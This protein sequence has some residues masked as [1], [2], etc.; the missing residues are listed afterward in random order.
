MVELRPYQTNI[1]AKFQAAV[2]RGHHRII[3]VV[4][5]AGGKT[6]VASEIIKRAT[7]AY[8]R[9]VFIAHRNELLTQAHDKL[10]AFGVTAGIVK[11]GRDKDARPQAMVQICGVQTL[12]ARAVRAKTM[13]LPPA[14]I[15]FVDEAHHVRA[16]TYM[17]IIEQYPDAIIVGLTATPARGDGRGLGNVFELMI[18][19]P[20]V[21]ELI[22]QKYLVPAKI[23]APPPPDLR[24]VRVMSTG[25]YNTDDLSATMDPLVGDVIEHWL[26]HAQ[27]RRS[28]AFAVD[29]RHSVHLTDEFLKSDVRAEHLDGETDAKSRDAI[30]ARL[31]SGETEI[32]CNVGVLCEGYDLPDLGCITL[33]RPT[34][35]LVLYRQMIGRGL[36]PAPDKEHVV[37]LDHSGGVYRFGRPDDVIEWSLETD[38]RATNKTHEARIA[39]AGGSDP[40]VECKGC[41]HI[42][43]RGMACEACGYQP[44]PPARPVEYVDGELVELGKT[45]AAAAASET[46]RK[47][48]YA[49]L[50]G[51]Q[52]NARKRNGSPYANG[53]AANQYRTKHG[54]FPPWSWNNHPLATPSPATLRWIKSRQIAWAKRRAA[55]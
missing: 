2:E 38:E 10:A 26:K 40:F 36:R 21:L 48:F 12:H 7:A 44:K 24:G 4:P 33:A 49:E 51:Y 19:S 50:R 35:S 6:V 3:I 31:A 23:F 32:V 43:M 30:L 18:Q 5:T 34:R 14:E 45:A 29:I 22:E 46:E 27:R 8:Q 20:Q 17:S 39:K 13:E 25:D 11:A 42:R 28:I 53:W 1:V 16:R 47:I 9:V 15:V 54:S 41:G 37:I 52:K 55:S